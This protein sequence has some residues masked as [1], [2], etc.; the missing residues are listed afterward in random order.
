MI[1]IALVGTIYAITRPSPVSPALRDATCSIAP[2][3]WFEMC[4]GK[5]DED[6]CKRWPLMEHDVAPPMRHLH[7]E[8]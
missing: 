2:D 4:V 7:I 5:I 3:V 8:Y 1:A 6:H